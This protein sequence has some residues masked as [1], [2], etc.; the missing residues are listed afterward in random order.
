[1]FGEIKVR[2]LV[3]MGCS[4]LLGFFA[5]ATVI[6]NEIR[7]K[8]GLQGNLIEDLMT[9]SLV[10]PFG[11]IQLDEEMIYLEQKNKLPQ[12]GHLQN[13]HEMVSML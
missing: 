1:M 10:Y 12:N 13:R 2:G 6:R 4:L 11:I 8:N 9:L 7:E 5:Y 3:Y